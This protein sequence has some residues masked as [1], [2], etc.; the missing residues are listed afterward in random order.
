MSFQ[1]IEAFYWVVVLGS[2]AAAADHLYVTQSTISMRIKELEKHLGVELF[3]RS[4]R[5]AQPTATGLELMQYAR[6]L[7]GLNTELK[8][9][10]M[11]AKAFTGQI[12]IGVAEVVS[13]TWLPT[14]IEAV[15]T[16]FPRVRLEIDQMLTAD[17]VSHLRKGALDLILA[18][19]REP[20]SGLNTASLGSVQFSW[21]ASPKLGLGGAKRTAQ[22]ISEQAVIGLAR[23]SYHHGT[24]EDWFRKGHAYSYYQVRCTSML[25][26]A[27]MVSSG[28]GCAY[29]PINCFSHEIEAGRLELIDTSIE[30]QVGFIAAMSADEMAPLVFRIADLAVQASNFP[31]KKLAAL[32]E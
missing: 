10:I 18:P 26:A 14:F 21:M 19:G 29:L 24:I 1:Q 9:K 27:S 4:S 25:V 6:K 22:E 5:V 11:S 15:S 2:F 32:S 20:E 17:L 30:P 12:R 8:Q 16:T 28:V 31:N 23:Q 13:L 7:L 3:D